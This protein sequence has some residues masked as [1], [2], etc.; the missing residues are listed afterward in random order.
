MIHPS[1][2]ITYTQQRQH[3]LWREAERE[4]QAR[5]L[6]SKPS[7]LSRWLM[8]LRPT[9]ALSPRQEREEAASR[10]SLGHEEQTRRAA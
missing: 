7:R 5:Q 8:S 9:A 10:G 3:E 6:R 2:W 4:A 1:L